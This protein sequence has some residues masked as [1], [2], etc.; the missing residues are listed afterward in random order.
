MA[1]IGDLIRLTALRKL[2]SHSRCRK[3][4]LTVACKGQP[5]IYSY[6]T[7]HL[8]GSRRVLSEYGCVGF[9]TD[10]GG[11]WSAKNTF[12][13]GACAARLRGAPGQL[14]PNSRET[15]RACQLSHLQASTQAR[16]DGQ[17]SVLH[18]R[19]CECPGRKPQSL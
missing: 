10:A 1:P 6:C 9:R 17:D 7:R 8:S 3:G 13:P 4:T 16:S 15:Y 12:S 2:G 18:P 11:G 19:R 14:S 5:G